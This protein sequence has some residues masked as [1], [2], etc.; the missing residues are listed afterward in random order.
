LGSKLALTSTFGDYTIYGTYS[1]PNDCIVFI[2]G[3][4]KLFYITGRNKGSDPSVVHQFAT[5][6]PVLS[7]KTN[8]LV[9]SPAHRLVRV[10][11]KVG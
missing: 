9:I 11:P 8:G 2:F 1:S 4:E 3:T 7:A 6:A 10:A 5:G